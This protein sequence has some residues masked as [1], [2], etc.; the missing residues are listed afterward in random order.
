LRDHYA[1][2]ASGVMGSDVD[3]FLLG[4]PSAAA[5]ETKLRQLVEALQRAGREAGVEERILERRPGTLTVTSPY[6]HRP[7]QIVLKVNR[8]ESQLLHNFDV[9]SCGALWDGTALKGTWRTV[10]AMVRPDFLRGAYGGFISL[11]YSTA[12]S[13]GLPR[14]RGGP[15]LAR[16][17]LRG[18]PV[19]VLTTRVLRCGA[20]LRP[21]HALRRVH[22]RHLNANQV[23]S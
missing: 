16:Q 15:P 3:L 14:Q 12:T 20:R 13:A 8:S 22:R 6:P 18:A 5:A 9:D 2:E 1:S 17:E 19:E 11:I 7:V 23:G 10:R 4:L 21:L